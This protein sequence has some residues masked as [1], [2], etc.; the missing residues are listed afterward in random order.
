MD[1]GDIANGD[2][3]GEESDEPLGGAGDLQRSFGAASEL[4][5]EGTI[6][7]IQLLKAKIETYMKS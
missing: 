5:I 1:I 2:S 4:L 7:E 3:S 6:E